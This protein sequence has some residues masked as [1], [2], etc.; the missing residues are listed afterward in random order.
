MDIYDIAIVGGGVTGFAS[1]MYARRLNLRTLV[2]SDKTGGTI[3]LTDHVENYPGFKDISGMELADRIR[4]HALSYSP[5]LVEERVTA[6]TREGDCFTLLTNGGKSFSARTVLLATGAEH[7][8]LDVKGHD[9]FKNKGVHYCALCDC[10]FYKNKTVAVV[11]GSDSAT[12]EVLVLAQH[13]AR[14]YMIYR[15]EKIRPEPVN[16]DRIMANPHIE[17]ITRTNVTEIL[18]D[19]VVKGVRLDR[20]HKGSD[21]LALDG[22]FV[23]IGWVPNSELAEKLGASVNGKGE[24]VVNRAG[25]TTLPGVYAAGDVVDTFFKQAVT[26]VAQGVTAVYHAYVHLTKNTVVCPKSDE[27]SKA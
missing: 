11:G 20:A 4:E 13:A 14:V 17:I 15:G 26:G 9:E 27:D 3:L 18:G 21:T 25:E 6:V 7:K 10:A 2:L 22:V 12:K 19:G 23:A 16:Y 1:A 5:T 8:T 24:I